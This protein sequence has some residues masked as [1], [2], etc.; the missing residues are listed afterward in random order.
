MAEVTKD[1]KSKEGNLQMMRCTVVRGTMRMRL[2]VRGARAKN[3]NGNRG[4]KN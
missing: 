1:V 3:G 2:A 4:K